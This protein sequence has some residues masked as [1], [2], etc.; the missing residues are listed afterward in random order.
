MFLGRDITQ[1]LGR[2]FNL[3]GCGICLMIFIAAI[4]MCAFSETEVEGSVS[5]EW[6]EDGS[7]YLVMGDIIVEA[8]EE[9]L[10]HPGVRVN[11]TGSYSFTVEG[12]LRAE[13]DIEDDDGRIW[14]GNEEVY[15]WGGILFEPGSDGSTL[16]ACDILNTFNG[17]TC[18]S[19]DFLRIEQCQIEAFN[20][21]IRCVDASPNIYNN[22]LI[23]VTG[24]SGDAI[25]IKLSHFSAPRII[26]NDRII[27]TSSSGPAI[28]I[29][30]AESYPVIRGN[31]VEVESSGRAFGIHAR[32]VDKLSIERNIIRVYSPI[33]MK[34]LWVYASLAVIFIHND[35]ILM[36]SS[37]AA[38]AITVEESSIS[39]INNILYGNGLSIGISEIGDSEVLALSGY[40]CIY[41]HAYS[42]SGAYR[43][44]HE[45]FRDPLFVN[46]VENIDLADYH[47]TG[48]SP[49]IERGSPVFP[50]DDGEPADIGRWQFQ[51]PQ[52]AVSDNKKVQPRNFKLLTAYP[53]PFNSSAT[54]SFNLD[55]D[56]NVILSLFETNGRLIE[57]LISQDLRAGNHL[58]NITAS[59]LTSGVYLVT[60]NADGSVQ[61][62]KIILL[63]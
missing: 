62:R 23:Q 34:G 48:E 47:L 12:W 9:L 3:A 61:T 57:T 60:L 36:P 52:E 39:I 59:D 42:F 29:S 25:A 38:S 4:P 16:I 28:G 33:E 31:W 7:P 1:V 22:R 49:C 50:N 6:D 5:G 26:G 17:V 18:S 15:Q 2:I 45:V 51:I 13:G 63:R 8:E 41:S 44:N 30:I 54:L 37:G 55:F 40:N 24:S 35:I 11:F 14:F 20:I 21:G 32:E 53:N 19:V 43:G 10:I 58:M 46:H 27:S 56:S